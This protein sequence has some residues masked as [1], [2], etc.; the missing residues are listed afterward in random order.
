M[1]SRTRSKRSRKIFLFE[2]YSN[3]GSDDHIKVHVSTVEYVT[4]EIRY[5]TP[6]TSQMQCV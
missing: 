6:A 3:F 1:A 4:S 5:N 2:K